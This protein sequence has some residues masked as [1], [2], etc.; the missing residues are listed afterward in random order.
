MK[1]KSPVQRIWELGEAEHGGLI[2]AVV[3]VVVGVACG[4]APYFAAKR[5]IAPQPA[6]HVYGLRLLSGA[7]AHG[8][9]VRM[10]VLHARHAEHRNLPHSHH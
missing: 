8:S 3:L 6:W 10:A 7:D 9:A 1:E 2:A 5:I 4:M